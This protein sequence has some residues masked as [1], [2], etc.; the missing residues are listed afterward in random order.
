MRSA[1]L[2]LVA[3]LVASP[4]LARADVTPSGVKTVRYSYEIDN[5]SAHPE[6]TFV[7]W[8]R[9]CTFDGRP[10]GEAND[11]R[12]AHQRDYEVVGPGPHELLGKCSAPARVYALDAKRFP[13][14][15][16]V[17][18]EGDWQLG[19]ES[20]KPYGFVPAL[21][22]MTTPARIPFFAKARKA[23]MKVPMVIFVH[24]KS[25]IAA[26]HDVLTVR[27]LD[28]EH[29]ELAPVSAQYELVTG[30]REAVAWTEGPRPPPPTG[31]AAAL[32]T[33]GRGL[34]GGDEED[35]NYGA[36]DMFGRSPDGGATRAPPAEQAK[37]E[38]RN[39]SAFG[40]AAF[41]LG[42]AALI[43]ARLARRR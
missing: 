36:A 1:S 22:A 23:E 2:L 7:V 3:G 27:A 33:E 40:V 13:V 26:V 16:R 39:W 20:G 8:P 43:V 18:T 4:T 14:Q 5:V 15:R 21:D 12:I 24:R 35:E 6:A 30:A 11:E 32:A 17:A 25:P 29:F 41:G 10:L 37:A 19:D 28:A 42:A 31:G 9:M 38:R 34:F